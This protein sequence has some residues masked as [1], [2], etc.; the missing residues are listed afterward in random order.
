MVDVWDFAEA[1]CRRFVERGMSPN[2]AIRETCATIDEAVAAR[3]ET[4]LAI[5]LARLE[6]VRLVKRA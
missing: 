1:M 2:D 4:D 6:K 3:K 5:S